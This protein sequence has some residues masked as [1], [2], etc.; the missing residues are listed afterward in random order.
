MSCGLDVSVSGS[1]CC[2]C[3]AL[4]SSSFLLPFNINSEIVERERERVCVFSLSQRNIIIV[5]D[6]T[7]QR[8]LAKLQ[9]LSSGGFGSPFLPTNLSLGIS[10]GPWFWF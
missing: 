5:G 7:T 1:L 8:V 6:I 9:S 3:V 4:S 10:L 2:D